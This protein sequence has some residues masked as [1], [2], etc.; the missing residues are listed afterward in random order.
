MHRYTVVYKKLSFTVVLIVK[1]YTDVIMFQPIGAE[2]EI[3]MLAFMF[4]I[5][6]YFILYL[7]Y[8]Y[9]NQFNCMKLQQLIDKIDNKNT[10]QR[11]LIM[12]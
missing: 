8:N 10:R 9:L 4:E 7:F 5:V 1:P 2:S 12:S 3:W 6:Q 11:I